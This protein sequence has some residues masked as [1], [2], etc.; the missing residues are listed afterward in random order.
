[1]FFYRNYTNSQESLT[2]N[3]QRLKATL[4][5]K[6]EGQALPSALCEDFRRGSLP[7]MKWANIL[8]FNTRAIVLYIVLLV[9]MPWIYFIFELTV[10]NVIFFYM[11]SKH[12]KLCKTLLLQLDHYSRK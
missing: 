7:L 8:T 12:E 10:M 2:P 1:M 6:Y 3:F 5:E 11:R 9:G 4:K